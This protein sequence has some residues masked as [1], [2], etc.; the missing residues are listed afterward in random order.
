MFIAATFGGL[1]HFQKRSSEGE[2]KYSWNL[3]DKFNKK[4]EYK[5]KICLKELFM[6]KHFSRSLSISLFSAVFSFSLWRYNIISSLLKNHFC[7]CLT[8][9]VR[10]RERGRECMALKEKSL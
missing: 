8:A 7:C 10:E 9:T 4:K 6:I 3:F 2:N 5:N 1:I